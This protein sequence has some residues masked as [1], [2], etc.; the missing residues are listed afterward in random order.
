M[1]GWL[2]VSPRLRWAHTHGRQRVQLGGPLRG[3]DAR[4]R[5]VAV[6]LA[7]VTA[8]INGVQQVDHAQAG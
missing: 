3:Q 5:A 7:K 8:G 4:G 1:D 2:G 6:A